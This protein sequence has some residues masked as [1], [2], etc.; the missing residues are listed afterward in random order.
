MRVGLWWVARGTDPWCPP[1][2]KKF[3]ITCGK[4]RARR[5][6]RPR[7]PTQSDP[8]DLVERA[9]PPTAKS[10]LPLDS[11]ANPTNQTTPAR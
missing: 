4:F 6:L 11:I 3:F 1:A 10:S 7:S 8:P 5:V 2:K 9:L